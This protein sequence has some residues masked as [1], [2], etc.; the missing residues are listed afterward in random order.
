MKK[1]AP[2]AKDNAFIEDFAKIKLQA[3]ENAAKFLLKDT[4]IIINPNTMIDVQVKRIH[5]Y[6]RQLLN[7]LNILTIYT[8][9][10]SGEI[11]AEDM[12]L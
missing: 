2:F 6:K 3:K 5:E 9:L 8:K 1:L 7:A 10:K 11:K 12:H 4:G